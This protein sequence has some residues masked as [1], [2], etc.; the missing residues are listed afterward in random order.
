MNTDR[1]NMPAAFLVAAGGLVA[2]AVL[3]IL[4]SEMRVE[5]FRPLAVDAANTTATNS[6]LNDEAKMWPAAMTGG[7]IVLAAVYLINTALNSRP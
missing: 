4:F 1:A 6:A 7:T 5:V 2:A 3:V